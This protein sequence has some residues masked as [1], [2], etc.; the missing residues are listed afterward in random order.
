MY[1][2]GTLCLLT[3]GLVLGDELPRPRFVVLGQQG[4][5]KSSISNALLGFD[6]TAGSTQQ[7]RQSPF[8]IGHGLKSKTQ[9]TT[10]SVGQWLGRGANV[11]VI[12]TPGFKDTKDAA[13]VEE[14]TSVLGDE[15]P[16][17]DTFLIVFKY[18]DRF[19]APFKRTLNMVTKMF[20]DIWP[21]V[22]VV[23]NFW[24]AGS[25]ASDARAMHGVTEET[26]TKE[27]QKTFKGQIKSLKH[28]VPVVFLD[29]HY[30]RDDQKEVN[31]F[32]SQATTL[33]RVV[34]KMNLFECVKRAE[35]KN[36]MKNHKSKAAKQRKKAMRKQRRVRE[37]VRVLA[38][39]MKSTQSMVEYYKSHC[40]DVIPGCVWGEWSDWGSCNEGKRSRRR[41][42][43]IGEGE[44]CEG[45]DTE[46]EEGCVE[47][48]TDN[49]LEDPNNVAYVFGGLLTSEGGEA[50]AKIM[51]NTDVE[52]AAPAF[53]AW[54]QR[55]AAAYA[56]GKGIMACGGLD[57]AGDPSDQCWVFTKEK[58]EWEEATNSGAPIS[59]SASAWYKGEFWMVGGNS[60]KDSDNPKTYKRKFINNAFIYN[61]ETK[62]WRVETNILS[63]P[64]HEACMVNID[65]GETGETLVLTGGTNKKIQLD[66]R[67][68]GKRQAFMHGNNTNG[69]EPLPAMKVARASHSCTVATIDGDLGIVVGG[70]SNDGDSIE[71]LDWDEKKKWVMVPR[72]SRQR[73]IGPGMAFVRGKL[74]LVGGYT[75]PLPVNEVEW[76][77]EEEDGWKVD[78]KNEDMRFNH[79]AL[80]VPAEFLPKCVMPTMLPLFEFSLSPFGLN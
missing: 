4:V 9:L 19:T 69:W 15:V 43:L 57:S 72:L 55:M 10:F 53:P 75:W 44:H 37:Q 21:N 40:P 63:S 71:F 77:D 17:V 29:S 25:D 56:P 66:K 61:P 24:D 22:A 41:P 60:A 30:S 67:L 74:T 20:G 62:A 48:E 50:E 47:L 59:G 45:V 13:F 7:R 70:G 80:T 58:K 38:V 23:V 18:K 54:R 26:Y 14:L 2:G 31:F 52:C 65:D 39:N 16:E 32:H 79:V 1:L 42:K 8:K 5:G 51:S 76:F 3:L 49:W 64:L 73:R 6:N 36:I 33:Y 27:L 34:D 12:D 35:I 11:T 28:D 78:N 68:V 46:V